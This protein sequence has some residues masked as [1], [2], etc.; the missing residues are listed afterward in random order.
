MKIITNWK[1]VPVKDGDVCL[2]GEVDG[3]EIQTSNIKRVNGLSVVTESGT[4]YSLG[5]KREGMWEIQLQLKRPE[6]YN[7]LSKHGVVD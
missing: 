2:I 5:K 1:I 6:K 3:L 7:N 4:I